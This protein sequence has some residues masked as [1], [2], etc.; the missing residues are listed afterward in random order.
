MPQGRGTL[1]GPVT[2][3]TTGFEHPYDWGHDG[4]N[5]QGDYFFYHHTDGDNVAILDP[6]QMDR[7]SAIWAAHALAIANL[8]TLLPRGPLANQIELDAAFGPSRAAG[9]ESITV[10]APG[11]AAGSAARRVLAAALG[12]VSRATL[13]TTLS[14]LVSLETRHSLSATTP[15]PGWGVIPAREYIMETLQSY[16]PAL[17]VALDCY[18]VEAEGRITV[19]AELCNVVGVLP[20][21]TARRVYISGH[22]DTCSIRAETR[23]FDWTRWDNPAPGAND[24]GSGTVLMMEVAR[25]VLAA[26][27]AGASAAG[28]FDATLVFVAHVAEEEGLNGAYLH[29]EL[30][31]DE[32]YDIAGILNNDIIGSSHGGAGAYDPFTMRVFSEGD[33]DSPSRHLARYIRDAAVEYVP[34]HTVRLIA[35][36]DRFGR[37][38]DHTPYN[39]AGFTAVRITESKENYDRQHTPDD[40]LVGVDFE[41]LAK[42]TRVN[43]AAL[44]CLA[45]APPQPKIGAG[46]GGASGSPMLTRGEGYDAAMQ[47]WPSAGAH[48]YRVV[49]RRTWAQEWE[50]GITVPASAGR[51]QGY[52][53]VN[54]TIDDFVFGVAAVSADGHTSLVTAYVRPSRGPDVINQVPTAEEGDGANSGGGFGSFVFGVLVGVAVS[55]AVCFKFGK[56]TS[57]K[58]SKVDQRPSGSVY[59]EEGS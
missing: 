7:S 54:M 46:E 3:D 50:A 2:A 36:E 24:D 5:F 42:N 58:Y 9:A 48:S 1:Y 59:D 51:M 41:Y 45:S 57:L 19:P 35:R 22:Y 44:F 52:T 21:K 32:G 4:T 16:S 23:Q 27:P 6:A 10:A 43:L 29:A 15:R 13:E 47:W 30:A 56:R 20:G 34:D 12:G 40:T 18:D 17:E 8:P 28:Y 31:V 37:G 33:A 49:W 26:L 25:A 38:G 39:R 53:I 55:C 11:L 14:Y